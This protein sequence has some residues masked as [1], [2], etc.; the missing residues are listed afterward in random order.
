MGNLTGECEFWRLL[1]ENAADCFWL[2]DL[3]GERF[4]YVSP[5]AERLWGL[6]AQSVLPARLGDMLTPD[7][8]ELARG[9]IRRLP[10]GQTPADVSFIQE[11]QLIGKDGLARTVEASAR[12]VA[13]PEP[14]SIDL[15]VV[16]RDI[17]GRRQMEELLRQEVSAK[18]D[19]IRKL[20]DNQ[21]ELVRLTSELLAKNETLRHLAL[22]DELTGLNNRYFFDRRIDEEIER[23]ERYDSSLSLILFDLDHF[24]EVNDTWG[25][26]T[27]DAILIAI[28]D[29]VRKSIRKPDILARWGGEEFILLATQTNL[30]GAITLAEKLR[31]VIGS[32]RHGDVGPVTASFGVAER[33][34]GESYGAWFRRADEA[35]YRAKRSGRNRVVGRSGE[36]DSPVAQIR[37]EWKKVWE[38]GNLLIDQEHR[39]IIDLANGLLDQSLSDRGSERMSNLFNQ[40]VQHITSHFADEEKILAEINYPEIGQH[41]SRHRNLTRKVVRLNNSYLKAELKPSALFSYIVDDV[42]IGHLLNDDVLFFPYI[43]I[44]GGD[45]HGSPGDH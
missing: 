35:L 21:T 31:Q 44:Q 34:S 19:T 27:G 1:V 15:L 33:I 17:A 26:D 7:L 24:K 30:P 43:R 14:G 3:A 11:C 38:C 20:M 2:Y 28:T 6:P 32:N 13:G 45:A 39:E 42:V 16:A 4:R 23:A 41:I 10:A 9:H 8:A 12:L 22:T 40:L 5:A 29:L 37:L 25:H 18:D 36:D